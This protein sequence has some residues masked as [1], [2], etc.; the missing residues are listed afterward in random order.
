MNNFK[1]KCIIPVLLFFSL[2]LHSQTPLNIWSLNDTYSTNGKPDNKFKSNQDHIVFYKL[3]KEALKKALKGL[4]NNEVIKI[5]FPL[6]NGDLVA[7]NVTES[8]IFAPG[9]AKKYPQIKTYKGTG[10]DNPLATLRFSVSQIGLHAL[11]H[12]NSGKVHYIEPE[13]KESDVYKV[14]DRGY[15]GTQKIGL[16]C[17]TE[18]SST[19][20]LEEVSSK[21]SNRAVTNDVN[22]F[23]DSKLRTFRLA[24]S[25]TGE[26]ANLFKGNGTEVQQKANVLAEMTKAINRVN[27]IYERDL[28]IRLV[29][30][31]NMDDVIYLD[32][33]TDP[34]GGEYNTKTAETLDEVI[35]VNNYDIG[36]NFNTSDGGSAGCI[37]CVCKQASQSSSHKGRGYT[38]LPDPTGDP[39]YIDYVCHEMGHQ[40]G[41]YHT[42]NKCDRGNQFTGSEVEPGSG[43]SIMGY[44]G[45]CNPN[46]QFNSDAH[47]NYVNIKQIA[48]YV[49]NETGASCAGVFPIANQ[50]P[51]ANAGP[52]Y[53]IP[54]NTAFVLTGSASDGDGL[55]SLTYNWSQNDP[56]FPPGDTAPQSDWAQ[57]ALYRSLLPSSSPTRYFPE[58]SQVVNGKI[59][60]TWE[61]TPSVA[62]TLN[63][64]FTVRDNG[65]GF[66]GD[67]GIGQVDADLMKV[68][69]IETGSAFEVTSQNERHSWDVGAQETVVWN[70]AGTS[71]NGINV[72]HV[73]ILMSVNDGQTFDVI[74][75]E[76]VPNNGSYD[77]TVPDI[78]GFGYKIMVKARDNIFY[79][80]NEGFV[81]IGYF[82]N[83][84]CFTFENTT[85]Y[86]ITDNTDNYAIESSVNVPSKPGKLVD[87]NL[88]IDVTHSYI[89]DLE[90]AL[91]NPEGTMVELMKRRDCSSEADLKVVFDHEGEPFDCSNTGSFSYYNSFKDSIATFYD[92]IAEG[93]WT[94]K[95]GDHGPGDVGILNN[96]SLELCFE[97]VELS[98]ASLNSINF[99]VYPN[100]AQSLLYLNMITKSNEGYNIKLYDVNGRIV[101]DEQKANNSFQNID[102]SQYKRGLYFFKITQNNLTKVKRIILN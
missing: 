72:S 92:N 2:V 37:G 50:A 19:L 15:Y 26:Y 75:A 94:L 65:S 4:K 98:N 24:L 88:T 99:K 13:S 66:S 60:T 8:S 49:I 80:I 31:D 5:N 33:S 95:I 36:H 78:K 89:G 28:G 76:N 25:C 7:F 54:T 34:W 102:V 97:E 6:V 17:F 21:I 68:T 9:L 43:S 64:A 27:E 57:G 82:V 79:A 59:R 70:V 91:V 39:F 100:P 51:I 96:W 55:N 101:L 44:A 90:I 77:V 73:D 46:V 16:D 40:F 47:F 41:A 74:L 29:F 12:D 3:Q 20:D 10:I 35:G 83:R 18:S 11:L 84:S 93:D 14:F 62:R 61:V 85:D 52:D 45:I 87:V 30:V 42:M 56:N 58:L 1:T 81:E 38:G 32:A 69:V 86:N 53:T 63:F 48:D 67:N 23:E 71:S 22:L